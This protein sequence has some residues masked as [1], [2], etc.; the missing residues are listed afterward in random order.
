MC[1]KRVLLCCFAI[2]V[3]RRDCR[4]GTE[5]WGG[6]AL[7]LVSLK[8][9]CEAGLQPFEEGILAG[10]MIMVEAGSGSFGKTANCYKLQLLEQMISA[11]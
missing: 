2:E 5:T 3:Q 4:A 7:W 6:D 11:R 9:H 10:C 1:N 8:G